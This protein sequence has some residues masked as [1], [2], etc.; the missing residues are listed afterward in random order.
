[1]AGYS[2][3]FIHAMTRTQFYHPPFGFHSRAR[4]W[5]S[6]SWSRVIDFS[7]WSLNFPAKSSPWLATGVR[8]PFLTPYFTQ[9]QLTKANF[10][11]ALVT[12]PNLAGI[13]LNRPQSDLVDHNMSTILAQA[14]YSL[15]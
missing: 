15:E 7:K 5:A 1:M 11:K 13:D 9:L 12:K 8:K 14:Y 6:A 3:L 4:R 2:L 10:I